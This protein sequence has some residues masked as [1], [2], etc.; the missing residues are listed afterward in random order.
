MLPEDDEAESEEEVTLQALLNVLRSA[1]G[2][3]KNPNCTVHHGGPKK[4]FQGKDTA[5]HALPSFCATRG[6]SPFRAKLL[7]AH[8]SR[9]GPDKADRAKLARLERPLNCERLATRSFS[10]SHA[11]L[12]RPG[13][14]QDSSGAAS[15]LQSLLECVRDC[16]QGQAQLAVLHAEGDGYCLVHA[17][18]RAI[19]G[20]EFFWHT[21]CSALHLHLTQH[22]AEYLQRYEGFFGCDW[23]DIVR[24]AS[25]DFTASAAVGSFAGL[26]NIHIFGLANCL[27]RPIIVFDRPGSAMEVSGV[28]LPLL[29]GA[30]VLDQTGAKVPPLA[31]ARSSA[32]GNHFVPL[33]PVHFGGPVVLP[34]IP[35]AMLPPV[36]GSTADDLPL[37]HYIDFVDGCCRVGGIASFERGFEFQQYGLMSQRFLDD[38]GVSVDVVEMA[39]MDLLR[40]QS[41]IATPKLI[42]E[43]VELHQLGCLQRCLLCQKLQ[44][45]SSPIS[46]ASMVAGGDM[47]TRAVGAVA[48]VMSTVEV[49]VPVVFYGVRKLFIFNKVMDEVYEASPSYI[50]SLYEPQALLPGGSYYN[51]AKSEGLEHDRIYGYKV[52]NLGFTL[53]F[54]FD[55]DQNRLVPIMG[56][57]EYCGGTL[58]A[59]EGCGRPKYKPGDRIIDAKEEM[60]FWVDEKKTAQLVPHVPRPVSV[61]FSHR[62]KQIVDCVWWVDKVSNSM[63][64]AQDLVAKHFPGDFSTSSLVGPLS[65]VIFDTAEKSVTQRPQLEPLSRQE[66]EELEKGMK[67]LNG[68]TSASEDR[69]AFKPNVATTSKSSKHMSVVA[70]KEHAKSQAERDAVERTEKAVASRQSAREDGDQA[71]HTKLLKMDT[72]ADAP[73]PAASARAPSA[74]PPPAAPAAAPAAT[75]A[76]GTTVSV[77]PTPSPARSSPPAPASASPQSTLTLGLAARGSL[78]LKCS[79]VVVPIRC[80]RDAL[81]EAVSAALAL[82]PDQFHLCF[83]NGR[84]EEVVPVNAEGLV[85]LENRALLVVRPVGDAAAPDAQLGNAQPVAAPASGVQ[86]VAARQLDY[87]AASHPPHKGQAGMMTMADMQHNHADGGDPMALSGPINLAL[88]PC[89]DNHENCRVKWEQFR[90]CMDSIFSSILPGDTALGKTFSAVLRI[91]LAAYFPLR[92]A[93]RISF[94]QFPAVDFLWDPSTEVFVLLPSVAAVPLPFTG[95]GHSLR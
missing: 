20:R 70:L 5:M 30:S 41:I 73:T 85:T 43:V 28:F 14:G 7:G 45:T 64:I 33:V 44:Y 55:S 26:L 39:V 72:D 27:Q 94:V 75:P 65:T 1:G 62:G 88:A 18:S 38:H 77:V 84:R 67:D 31:I 59:I 58:R 32:S 12:P 90:G 8:F 52:G 16:N 10:I 40:G 53:R 42:A 9:F 22:Q 23:T 71:P 95:K 83:M 91:Y 89:K 46:E 86:L 37:S 34:R 19:V 61:T 82:P 29:H 80:H 24:E 48:D 79:R 25:P 74:S 6:I 36:W 3:C 49:E 2:A 17:I 57:C 4:L 69:F 13:F 47:H 60:Y 11:D 81:Q 76:A 21:L 78:Q 66:S 51:R 54:R 50:S 93:S 68:P 15:Y 35:E 56:D 92:L 63:L 87:P